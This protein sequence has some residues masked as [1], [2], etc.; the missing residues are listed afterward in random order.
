MLLQITGLL[1]VVC[2][3]L[4]QG[5]RV[6]ISDKHP[7][8]E[9]TITELNGLPPPSLQ[10]KQCDQK[11]GMESGDISDDQ[12]TVSSSLSPYGKEHARLNGDSV[13]VTHASKEA[14]IQIDLGKIM[15]VSGIKTQSWPLSM[16]YVSWLTAY[17]VQFKLYPTQSTWDIVSHPNGVEPV[18][19]PGN[20]D[21]SS[22]VTQMF[23]EAV[24]AQIVRISPASILKSHYLALR[25]EIL[26]CKIEAQS[27][28][29]SP[30]ILTNPRGS[31][32]SM[33]YPRQYDN[34]AN[35]KW[36]I[37]APQD[38]TI[39]LKFDSGFALEPNN[40]IL[41]HVEVF[42]VKENVERS[43]GKY[44]GNKGPENIYS[45][46]NIL[47]IRFMTD[48]YEGETGFRAT[49]QFVNGSGCGGPQLLQES[50]G[51]IHSM[52]YP[53]NYYNQAYC[54]WDVVA[55]ADQLIEIHFLELHLQS[56]N[57]LFPNL[58]QGENCSSDSLQITYLGK[59]KH[60][61]SLTFC[62]SGKPK[63]IVSDTNHTRIIFRSDSSITA[64]GFSAN[65]EAVAASGCG[66]KRDLRGPSGTITS[67]N[68]PKPYTDGL[69][70]E[71]NII[72]GPNEDIT[73][74][75]QDLYI[76]END[77]C[78]YDY[79][80]IFDGNSQ[81]L[82]GK[83]CNRAYIEP[84]VAHSGVMVVHFVSDLENSGKGFK[85]NYVITSQIKQ[86]TKIEKG[87]TQP[88]NG[89]VS[90][91]EQLTTAKLPPSTTED[92][93]NHFTKNNY[94]TDTKDKP[95]TVPTT[96]ETN[97]P[98]HPMVT[99]EMAKW[100]IVGLASVSGLLIILV[101]FGIFLC[102]RQQLKN[103]TSSIHGTISDRNNSGV[104]RNQTYDFSI[105]S[106]NQSIRSRQAE[107]TESSQV[108]ESFSHQG[109]LRQAPRDSRDSHI[110]FSIEECCS[111][112]RDAIQAA[113]NDKNNGNKA[114]A[115]K[116][117][118]NFQSDEEPEEDIYDDE[119]YESTTF[120]GDSD[121]NEV[122]PQT[123]RTSRSNTMEEN[124]RKSSIKS[125]PT[126]SVGI[127]APKMMVNNILYESADSVE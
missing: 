25:L 27:K 8:D 60:L 105:G 55:K 72:S 51:I 99:Q 2:V 89:V 62:G 65:Y 74:T 119:D 92:D 54:I 35:C 3:A 10:N 9:P 100:I 102:C 50:S 53:E 46:E 96:A 81:H 113:S 40:C 57:E 56:E 34:N 76:E 93:D 22:V 95:T 104:M 118:I 43:V 4:V 36:D 16:Q 127:S 90:T 112:K 84:L 67:L 98:Q 63:T 114:N 87:T 20:T 58:E 73:I 47:K 64:K 15:Y 37:I 101:L 32:S 14:W 108:S 77:D 110:Y 91:F 38:L 41:E 26:G 7:L 66:G 82:V 19:F 18:I 88:E 49:Y 1:F 125:E 109:T 106:T 111:Q 122:F 48:H 75:F 85:A 71:W 116:K 68:Y 29:G 123:A 30:R 59:E 97:E 24:Q 126:S 80:S 124:F 5:L 120:N 79:V 12:I 6:D 115:H 103:R 44:C 42:D 45:T 13:W 69:R 83:Y 107:P 94:K 31:F 33:N 23:Q 28:C 121:S 78:Q 21:A 86:T 70:C 39:V 11:L 117:Q 61:E 17:K 52:N